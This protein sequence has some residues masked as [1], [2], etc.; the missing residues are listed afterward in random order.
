MIKSF[1]KI[2]NIRITYKYSRR[3][4]YGDKQNIFGLV[5]FD[6]YNNRGNGR[7]VFLQVWDS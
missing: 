3:D 5:N 7:V 2:L 6:F 4:R 1:I